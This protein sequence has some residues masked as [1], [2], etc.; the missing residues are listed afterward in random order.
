MIATRHQVAG[1]STV[2]LCLVGFT[3]AARRVHEIAAR[4]L[5]VYWA[6]RIIV[7]YAAERVLVEALLGNDAVFAIF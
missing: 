6:G 1:G 2:R 5:R 4:V 3:L 7:R